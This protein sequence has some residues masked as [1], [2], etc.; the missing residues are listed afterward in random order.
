MTKLHKGRLAVSLLLPFLAGA[1]GSYFTISEI[2]TWYA[3]LVKP[4]FNPPNYIFGPVWTVL[5]F[6]MGIAFYDVWVKHQEKS[7]NW[8]G[9]MTFFLLQL[10]ANA[11]W[12]I[13]FFGFHEIGIALLVI[14]ILWFLLLLTMIAFWR[15][16]KVAGI[17]LLPYLAWVSFAAFLNGAILFLNHF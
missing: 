6:F 17:L 15:I 10:F 2:P 12:S 4:S 3:S 8:L 7:P 13:V 16:S 11:L 5:Y 1:V 14:H 9:G